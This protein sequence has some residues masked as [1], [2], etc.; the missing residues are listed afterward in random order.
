M[1]RGGA[2]RRDRGDVAAAA[3][4]ADRDGAT[5][6]ALSGSNSRRARNRGT[7]RSP[8]PI[9]ASMS[10]DIVRHRATA[11]EL[12]CDAGVARRRVG[13]LDALGADLG[14]TKTA[15]ALA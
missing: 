10:A 14:V 1:S 4:G 12:A 3:V 5:S 13:I 6:F 9:G 7:A 15:P 2:Q 11:R 8:A